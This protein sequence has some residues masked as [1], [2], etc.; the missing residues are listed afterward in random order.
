MSRFRFPQDRSAFIWG[1]DFAPILTPP[2]TPL[3]IYTNQAATT[4]ADIATLDGTPIALSTVYVERGLIPEF[5]GPDSLSRLWAKAPDA[6]PYPLEAQVSSLLDD[7]GLTAPSDLRQTVV[8]STVLS[9][10]RAVTPAANGQVGYASNDNAAHLHAPLWITLG[11]ASSGGEVQV[12]KAGPITEP[13]WTWT[14]GAPVYLGTNGTLTQTAPA[15]P[16]AVFLAQLGVATSATTL[17]V[18]RVPSIRLS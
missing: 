18:D 17:H 14:P 12:M 16:G 2:R 10:H 8:A 13:S 4:T 6:L 3:V 5:L 1:D 9:G 15:L 11:A 7:V